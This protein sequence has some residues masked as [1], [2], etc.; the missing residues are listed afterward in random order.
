MVETTYN[1]GNKTFA[2]FTSENEFSIADHVRKLVTGAMLDETVK[3]IRVVKNIQ[4][5]EPCPCGSG[6]KFGRCRRKHDN[7]NLNP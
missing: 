2:T 6:M 4:A 1:N 3:G 7:V 5:D